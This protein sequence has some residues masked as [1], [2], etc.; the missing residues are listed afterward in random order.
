MKLTKDKLK[1]FIK[2]EL[3]KTLAEA[4]KRP[5]ARPAPRPRNPRRTRNGGGGAAH[6]S[7]II[8]A[9]KDR[10]AAALQTCTS[11]CGKNPDISKLE[12]CLDR[13]IGTL[14]SPRRR[15]AGRTSAPVDIM[16][17]GGTSAP[18]GRASL[19]PREQ[20]AAIYRELGMEAP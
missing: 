15:Q 8:R 1:Q 4:P 12:A 9:L 20:Q 13:C 18:S 6:S 2:E 11:A 19:T 5:G 3:R 7:E 10:L 17:S 16:S 14:F